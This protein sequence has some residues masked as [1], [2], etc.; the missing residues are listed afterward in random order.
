[1]NKKVLSVAKDFF[2]RG[3]LLLM[4]LCLIASIFG[5]VVISS[6]TASTG[7]MQ[8]VYIQVLA[9][10]I[11]LG[12]YVFFTYVDI[13]TLADNW[14]ILTVF[15][16]VLMSSLIFFGEAGDTGN[17]GWLRFFGIGVQPSEVVKVVYIVVMAKHI[18]YLKAR[19]TL[20][21]FPSV[22]GLAFHFAGIFGLIIVVS[23]D[24]G[25]ATIFFMIF[26]I[27]LFA[28]GFA[29]RWFM[30][31]FAAILAVL[32][33][34]WTYVLKEY[35]RR[36]LLVPYVPSIDPDNSGINWQANQSKIALA[37]GQLTGTGLYQGTQ[38][39]S[40]RAGKHTDFIFSVIGEELGMIACILCI[41][42]LIIIAIRCVYVGMHSGTNLGM[43][44]C[45][46][47]AASVLYQ[48]FENTGMCMG[49]TPV[50]GITLPFF[51]YGGSSVVSMWA[52]MG[53]VSGIKYKRKP[54]QYSLY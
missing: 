15:N 6:A 43:L 41:A 7:S 48:T 31:G 20:N 23:Q 51:S 25:S 24:L 35:Q 4:A 16:I 13:D 9:I 40:Q 53:I 36:R 50:I 21:D 28:A 22:V 1:M 52:A 47:V 30:I 3:D 46:G 44:V 34:V 19:N 33:I 14:P 10:F 8:Y 17:T 49:I 39:Q 2:A 11:G 37:S 18:S 5:V 42:L 38:S 27:M 54:T 32:P 26:L 29:A 45:V 12:L